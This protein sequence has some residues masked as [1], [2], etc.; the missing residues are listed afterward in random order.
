MIIRIVGLIRGYLKLLLFEKVVNFIYE[1]WYTV[2]V[3]EK[4]ED[5]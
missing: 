2:K 1:Q 4:S 3:R 5:N